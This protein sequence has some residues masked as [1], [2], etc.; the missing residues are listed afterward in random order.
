MN[1][2]IDVDHG[3]LDN[4]IL[5]PES[6][7]TKTMSHSPSP[8]GDIVMHLERSGIVNALKFQG[9]CIWPRLRAL[10][11]AADTTQIIREG[12]ATPAKLR[13]SGLTALTRLLE[14]RDDR[15]AART[16]LDH[17]CAVA[18]Q[19]RRQ[20]IMFI[21][22]RPRLTTIGGTAWNLLFDPLIQLVG[23]KARYV[24][25]T[26][27]PG[28]G[29]EAGAVSIKLDAL[30]DFL[31]DLDP[32]HSAL[33]P[34]PQTGNRIE[35]L[36]AVH[37][38]L[39]DTLCQRFT[40]ESLVKDMRAIERH[41]LV[42]VAMLEHWRP[43][44]VFFSGQNRANLALTWAARRLGIPTV[45]IQHGAAAFSPANIKWHT[46]TC[47]PDQGYD[48]LPDYFW[49]W[50]PAAA[51]LISR[52]ANPNCPYH[53]PLVGGHPNLMAN[54]PDVI[55]PE[56][57]ARCAAADKTVAV[58]LGLARLHGL[59]DPL[60]QAMAQAPRE[61]LWL[62][63]V[64]PQDWNDPD[65]M[66]QVEARLQAATV[67]NVA[68][69]VPTQ[70]PLEQVLPLA[71]RHVTPYSS[72]AVEASAFGIPTVFVHPLAKCVFGYLLKEPGY[73]YAETADAIGAAL[74]ADGPKPHS[75]VSTAGKRA[76]ALLKALAF[77]ERPA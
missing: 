44:V 18:E 6:Y 15:H 70:A 60:V 10:L 56:L 62:I 24:K 68:V 3:V 50:G 59:P 76:Q 2:A 14:E 5:G 66:A 53:R 32:A 28:I 42:L 22:D 34:V 72:S 30:A 25:L 16:A 40:E 4:D 21:G 77:G 54:L 51:A 35:G 45:D 75:M 17:I 61:W 23:P 7:D 27:E 12:L 31:G 26:T 38:A 69:R 19:H 48:L 29:V 37:D 65:A 47:I 57:R 9:V 58:T 8:C 20:P 36:Q 46:W 74:A 41:A 43:P 11:L 64:H 1:A 39:P 49:V 67:S 55:P 13:R 71:D 33:D 52:T 63:R 73:A